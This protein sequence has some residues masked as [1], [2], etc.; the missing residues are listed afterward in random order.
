VL[1][2]IS[3]HPLGDASPKSTSATD[4]EIGRICS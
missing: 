4:N 1:C 3:S 2:S